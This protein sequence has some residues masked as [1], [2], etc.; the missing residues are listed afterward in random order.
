[1]IGRS[2]YLQLSADISP[3]V[4]AISVHYVQWTIPV[5]V[6]TVSLVSQRR[7]LGVVSWY[8]ILVPVL[9]AIDYIVSSWL[10]S[11]AAHLW[12]EPTQN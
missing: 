3:Q 10:G 8:K 9:L 2:L 11:L 5:S 7:S 1:M 6:L 4:S 12:K